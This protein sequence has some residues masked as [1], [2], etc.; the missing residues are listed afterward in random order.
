LYINFLF[1][2]TKTAQNLHHNK[3]ISRKYTEILTSGFYG[4]KAV[5]Q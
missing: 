2:G 5:V 4:N 3:T 1:V